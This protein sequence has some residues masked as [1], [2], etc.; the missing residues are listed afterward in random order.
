MILRNSLLFLLLIAFA[1]IIISLFSTNYS[2]A[3]QL[4]IVAKH[5][6]ENAKAEVGAPN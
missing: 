5:Y 6:A 4:G 3:E 1:A 2:E